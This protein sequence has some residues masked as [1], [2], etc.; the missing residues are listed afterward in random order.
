[1]LKI[2]RRLPGQAYLLVSDQR[3]QYWNNATIYARWFGGATFIRSLSRG[4]LLGFGVDLHVAICPR[5]PKLR[6]KVMG[7][8]LLGVR[9]D[10]IKVLRL[11]VQ[12]CFHM[13]CLFFAL[14]IFGSN[15]IVDGMVS[16]EIL[17]RTVVTG[18]LQFLVVFWLLGRFLWLLPLLALVHRLLK[19]S[20]RYVLLLILM[21]HHTV[22]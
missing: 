21:V 14:V 8:P 6:Q 1:M 17:G 20:V 16:C 12:R 22:M 15:C 7:F 4:L 3:C 2:D 11:R 5:V 13:V 9:P 18:T 10:V 19:I